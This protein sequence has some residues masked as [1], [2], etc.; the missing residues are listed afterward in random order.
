M[1]HGRS[2][3]RHGRTS[4]SLNRSQQ[5]WAFIVDERNNVLKTY[6]IGTGVNTTVRPGAACPATFEAFMRSGPFQ[7]QDPLELCRDAIAFWHRYLDA[8]DEQVAARQT[9]PAV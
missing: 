7:G 8:I 4:F 6:A 5:F 1:P 9:R 3:S 2:L